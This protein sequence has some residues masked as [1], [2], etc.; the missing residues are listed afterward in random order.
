[1]TVDLQRFLS[2]ARD[3]FIKDGW[4]S[5]IIPT[6]DLVLKKEFQ[7][8][9]VLTVHQLFFIDADQLKKEEIFQI[10]DQIHNDST[11][12]PPLV[13]RVNQ[14]IFVFENASESI[15]S[16][17]QENGKEQKVS[18]AVSTVCWSVDLNH[19]KLFIHKGRPFIYKGKKEIN[20]ILL[21]F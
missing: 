10:I 5:S 1:M 18:T 17:L 14:I 16:L 9:I 13:S 19:K 12:Q 7:T 8:S 21:Q 4:T 11:G 6:V 15:V 2:F 20:H 3:L